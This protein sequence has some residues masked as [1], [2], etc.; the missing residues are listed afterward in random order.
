MTVNFV[1]VKDYCKS[2]Q[3]EIDEKVYLTKNV[4][5][6]LEYHTGTEIITDTAYGQFIT[7]VADIPQLTEKDKQ[8]E[9]LKAQNN[10]LQIMLQAEREVRC[11]EDY[12][13]K[14]TEL[15]A[16]IEKMKKYAKLLQDICVVM[17]NDN[18]MVAVQLK[19]IVETLW[20]ASEKKEGLKMCDD[21]LNRLLEIKAGEWA[22][23][24]KWSYQTIKE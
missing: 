18:Y 8:I 5:N 9:E 3:S 6:C 4:A 10:N 15:E 17:G 21:I 1:S 13:K 7:E 23:I 22:E 2:V 24:T 11:N 20:D 12:L 16:Q 14:A 19:G